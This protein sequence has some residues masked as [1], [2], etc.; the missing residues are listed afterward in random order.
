MP[1]IF[2]ERT[3]KQAIETGDRFAPKFDENGLIPAIATDAHTGEVL[4]FAFMNEQALAKTLQTGKA[5]YYSRSRGKLWLK[6]ES[7]G[8]V[9]LV[10]QV[11]TDCDQDV[12]WL[13][14]DTQGAAACHV[15]YK[16]CF[17]REVQPDGTLKFVGGQKL[18]DPEAVYGK[19]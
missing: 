16:S 14:V 13:R 2:H 1:P 17:Y 15:G 11:L 12:I 5:H 19:G 4:M 8:H 7:S 9:Q 3:D 18:F 6:G 10:Q